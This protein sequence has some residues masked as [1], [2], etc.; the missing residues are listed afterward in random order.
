M[1]NPENPLEE[2]Q[3]PITKTS[4]PGELKEAL[5]SNNHKAF[6]SVGST[7]QAVQLHSYRQSGRAGHGPR[8]QTFRWTAQVSASPELT[9]TKPGRFGCLGTGEK[10]D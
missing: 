3:K 8:I 2:L 7:L 10:K 6:P 1:H 4:T 5:F 9:A